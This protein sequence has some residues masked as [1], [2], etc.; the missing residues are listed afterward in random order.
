MTGHATITLAKALK[1]KNRLAG[2]LAKVQSE[3]QQFNSVLEGAEQP[4]I[5]KLAE[6]RERLVA[7]LL[8]LKA[9]ISQANAEVQPLIFELAECKAGVEFFHRVNTRHGTQGMFPGTDQPMV[10]TAVLRKEEVDARVAALERRIDDLQDR[11]DQYNQ[12][13]R[14]DLDSGVLEAVG[15]EPPPRPTVR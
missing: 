12:A 2:R 1:V 3:I 4:P 10:F 14:I 13:T 15:M 5:K 8:A 7:L 9:A 6:E 11:L